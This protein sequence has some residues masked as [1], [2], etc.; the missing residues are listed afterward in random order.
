MKM[1]KLSLPIITAGLLLWTQP[2]SAGPV[3]IKV[4]D[5][6]ANVSVTCFDGDACDSNALVGQVTLVAA[7]GSWLSTVSTGSGYPLLGSPNKMIVDLNSVTLQNNG[8][9][10]LKL[11]LTQPDYTD[12]GTHLYKTDIGGTTNGTISYQVFMDD[13]NDTTSIFAPFIDFDDFCSDLVSSIGTQGPGAFSASTTDAFTSGRA[14]CATGYSVTT[15]ATIIHQ[16]GDLITSF[17]AETRE[18]PEPSTM[19]LVGLGAAALGWR[20]RRKQS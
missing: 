12:S 17:D 2:A 6:I 5:V 15:V 3:G 18:I 20:G 8:G 14:L 19:I 4:L 11:F 10:T 1:R 7:V 16:A 13:L 9:G